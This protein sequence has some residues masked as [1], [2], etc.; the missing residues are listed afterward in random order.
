[1]GFQKILKDLP[2]G[3]LTCGRQP[4]P[5][6]EFDVFSG[7]PARQWPRDRQ[8]RPHHPWATPAYGPDWPVGAFQSP[9]RLIEVY[10]GA[11]VSLPVRGA[12]H[13]PPHPSCHYRTR[14]ASSPECSLGVSPP[15]RVSSKPAAGSPCPANPTF[16]AIIIILKKILKTSFIKHLS[17]DIIVF[18][19][20]LLS[21]R[22]QILHHHHDHS[23]LV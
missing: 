3:I 11:G 15:R 6:A 23:R 22:C 5:R 21:L 7:Y 19:R 4:I 20:W 2:L 17:S 14:T 12:S 16:P 9:G 8:G 10:A 13:S 1:M 18:L